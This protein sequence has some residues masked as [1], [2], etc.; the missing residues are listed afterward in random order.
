MH[1]DPDFL[2]LQRLLDPELEAG[3]G[4][5]LEILMYKKNLCLRFPFFFKL[6]YMNISRV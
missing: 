5:G 3:C 1:Q 4:D 2:K 6:A